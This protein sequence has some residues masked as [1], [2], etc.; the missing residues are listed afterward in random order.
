[1]RPARGER[2]AMSKSSRSLP[3]KTDR[4]ELRCF[5]PGDLEALADYHILPAV[6]RYAFLRTRDRD[7]VGEALRVMSGH[8]SLQRAGDTLTLAVIR[9]SDRQLVGHVSLHWTDSTAS[10]G[11]VRFIVN[12]VYAGF[13]YT[14]EALTALFDLAFGHFGIHRLMVRS[15]GR[16]HNS[17][18]LMQGMGMRL[19]AHY[20]EHALFQGDWDE[21]LHF[22]I[23][24]RE[25]QQSNKVRDLPPRHRVA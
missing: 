19:E 13:G 7:Q 22:A 9:Q 10:Q 14:K 8:K 25:W 2:N 3:I 12:P 20:R 21:E 11:E 4:L 5:E 15:D 6:Q 17:I 18:K 1:M 24:D 16:N 23:L